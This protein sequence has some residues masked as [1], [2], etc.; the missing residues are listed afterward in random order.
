LP[1]FVPIEGASGREAKEKEASVAMIEHEEMK[2]LV[3]GLVRERFDSAVADGL[4]VDMV[5]LDRGGRGGLVY[6]GGAIVRRGAEILDG[7]HRLKAASLAGLSRQMR[8]VEID[9]DDRDPIPDAIY[10]Q[11]GPTPDYLVDRPSRTILIGWSRGDRGA[12][13]DE[14]RTAT[15]AAL[16]NLFG[17]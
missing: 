2:S 14:L 13:R 7:Y 16:A 5:N 3:L 11:A 8:V 1:I 6:L 15:M 17:N 12:T 9:E 10:V 4:T